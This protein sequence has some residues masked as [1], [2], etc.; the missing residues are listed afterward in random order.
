MKYL[1]LVEDFVVPAASEYLTMVYPRTGI[2]NTIYGYM[3][4][5]K[6]N[7]TSYCLGK[8]MELKSLDKQPEQPT[9]FPESFILKALAIAQNPEL[10]K[11]LV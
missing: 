10:A 11:E 9:S 2:Y 1:E 7:N 3:L 8:N 5:N 6:E 4:V